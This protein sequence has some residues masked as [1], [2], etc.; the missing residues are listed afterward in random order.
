MTDRTVE[1]NIETITQM[2]VMIGAGTGLEKHHFPEAITIEIGV[3]VIVDPGQ[4]EEQ[5]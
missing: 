2:T 4:D 5:V 3:Q 1:E